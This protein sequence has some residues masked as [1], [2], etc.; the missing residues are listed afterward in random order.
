MIKLPLRQWLLSHSK[1][2]W[3]VPPSTRLPK[4]EQ[5]DDT[6][7]IPTPTDQRPHLRPSRVPLVLEI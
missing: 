6:E 5:M 4:P 3:E 1:E 2:R 7:S